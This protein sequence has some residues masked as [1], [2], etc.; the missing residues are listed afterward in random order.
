MRNCAFP[1]NFHAR[2]LGEIT[3]VFAMHTDGMS[4]LFRKAITHCS[5]KEIGYSLD[6]RI[7]LSYSISIRKTCMSEQMVKYRKRSVWITSILFVWKMKLPKLVKTSWKPCEYLCG[8]ARVILR[9]KKQMMFFSKSKS[10]FLF[11][12]HV[13]YN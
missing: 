2:K 6:L 3:V 7:V 11:G 4:N 8:K 5:K 12:N 9:S 13:I 1:Q 10:K